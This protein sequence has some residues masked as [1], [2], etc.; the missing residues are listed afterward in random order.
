MYR[1]RLVGAAARGPPT[2]PAVREAFAA[3]IAIRG[4]SFA[5]VA[6]GGL[7]LAAARGGVLGVGVLGLTATGGVALA[8]RGGG[9]GR[10]G[11]GDRRLCRSL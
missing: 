3:G 6:V 4:L 9:L 8:A 2:A 7:F 1:A 5:L 11:C 10:A